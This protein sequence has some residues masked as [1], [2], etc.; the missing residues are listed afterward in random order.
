[1]LKKDKDL[2][3]VKQIRLNDIKEE[4][5]KLNE[6]VLANNTTTNVDAH[7]ARLNG[8]CTTFMNNNTTTTWHDWLS[9]RVTADMA[10][11]AID[12][13]AASNNESH[14]IEKAT[15]LLFGSELSHIND[16]IDRLEASKEELVSVM[17]FSELY[18]TTKLHVQKVWKLLQTFWRLDR[19]SKQVY[20]VSKPFGTS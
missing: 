10:K 1:M 18:T 9:N 3:K 2:L 13:I 11:Q 4:I 17:T 14:R 19:F 7:I 15:L 8:I 6:K 20:N 16:T 12:I 5:A